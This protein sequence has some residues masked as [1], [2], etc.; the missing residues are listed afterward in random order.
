MAQLSALRMQLQSENPERPSV[1]RVAILEVATADAR[2]EAAEHSSRME[3][4]SRD[5]RALTKSY[6]KLRT[7]LADFQAR[8]NF[9]GQQT[10][11]DNGHLI[12]R[13]NKFSARMKDAKEND[14]VLT[15]PLFRTSKYGYTLKAE[16]SLN[17]IGKWRGRNL[18]CTV[19]VVTG[20]YDPL[21]EW[22]CDL[23]VNIVLKDQPANR[24]QAM[25][26]VKSLQIRRK[27]SSKR[28]DQEEDD[29]DQEERERE[30]AKSRSSEALDQSVVQLKRQHVFVPHASLDKFDYVR[31]DVMFMEFIV[32]Q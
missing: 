12:W 11:S 23:N 18:T 6:H 24:K 16:L 21:L 27:S 1:D 5:L 8:V 4:I 29:H 13:I 32:N 28:H 3:L 30:K 9:D 19:R 17:G 22:P 20:A 26:I 14:T 15:S 10:G 25:D 2:A 31:D 7:E